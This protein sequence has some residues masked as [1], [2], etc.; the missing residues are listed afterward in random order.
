MHIGKKILSALLSLLLL[1]ELAPLQAF[2]ADPAITEDSIIE[3]A[4]ETR[5]SPAA[6]REILG[7]EESLREADAK[8]FLN[9]DGSYTAV[10]YA[11]PVHYRTE[12]DG[13]WLDIDNSPILT[14]ADKAPGVS[15]ARQAGSSAFEQNTTQVYVPQSSP[16]DVILATSTD[17]PYLATLN[18][19]THTVSWRIAVD[20]SDV[21]PEALAYSEAKPMTFES[22]GTEESAQI[23]AVRNVIRG[24][25]YPD[26]S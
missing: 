7:E 3:V 2:A 5:E 22:D 17:A 11:Q 4:D 6:P 20:R 16:L 10:K 26:V 9:T 18:S 8:H 25:V 12:P 13:D 21:Q 19:G 14:D 1:A 23:Q 24:L 15:R